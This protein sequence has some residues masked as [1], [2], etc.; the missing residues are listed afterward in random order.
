MT[1]KQYL[2]KC[3]K[4]CRQYSLIECADCPL[5][6]YGC[7]TPRER[8]DI[9]GC[10]KVVEDFELSKARKEIQDVSEIVYCKDCIYRGTPECS[11]KHERAD[12]DFCSRGTQKKQQH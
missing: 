5:G 2:T 7:G 10:I 11:A 3:I 9:A 8:K 6:Q 4:I 1:A 12:L